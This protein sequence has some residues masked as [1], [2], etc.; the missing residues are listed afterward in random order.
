VNRFNLTF[1]GEIQPGKDP[2]QVKARFGKLFGIDD[3]QR[4]ERFFSG[5]A[6]ILRRNL[7]RKAAAEYFSKLRKLGAEAEL[8]KVTTEEAAAALAAT[9]T[10]SPRTEP[11]PPVAAVE[12]TPQKRGMDHDI[13]Q[14]QPG[15]VDQ[16]WAVSTSRGKQAKKSPTSEQDGT[17]K[18]REKNARQAREEAQQAEKLHLEAEAQRAAAQEQAEQ[19]EQQR[20]EAARLKAE[21]D[22]RVAEVTARR[23]AQQ[24]QARLEAEEEAAREKAL[25]EEEK[26]K[27]EEEARQ[28]AAAEAKRK[29]A[30]EAKRKAAE[31]AERKA[32]E[33]AK[34][35]A[36]EEAKRKAAE[37][38][39]RKA[40]EEAE[41]KAAEEAKR[42]AAEEAK[43]KAAEE[44]ERKAAIEAQR[45]A[46]EE[47]KRKAAEEAAKRKAQEQ[48]RKAEQAALRKA[49]REEARRKA[50]EEAARRKAERKEQQRLK[51]EQ[52]AREKAEKDAARRKADEET[53]LRQAEEEARQK[54]EQE[55]A[56]R[57]AER[58]R[59]TAERQ[60][61]IAERGRLQAE[62]ERE[63]LQREREELER[64]RVKARQERKKLELERKQVERERKAA[65]RERVKAEQAK[66]AAQQQEQRK[67]MEEGAILRAAQELT[68]QPAL[69]PVT[70]QVKTRLETPR[71]NKR[72]GSK[73]AIQ[74]GAPNLYNLRPFRNT[75]AV[76]E[77]CQQAQQQTQ[78]QLTIAA[79]AL[80]ALLVLSGVYLNKAP[81]QLINGATALAIDPESGPLLLAGDRL[82]LHDRAGLGTGEITLEE[83]GISRLADSLSFD[84]KGNLL[85]LG[86][87]ST[88][89]QG[90]REGAALLRC[91]LQV[92]SCEQLFPNANN[93]GFDAFAIHPLDDS[94]F[95]VNANAGQLLHL[96]ADGSEL[97]SAEIAL[98]PLARLGL[99]SGLLFISSAAGP[100]ISVFRYDQNA[101]GKQLDEILL[102][103]PPAAEKGESRVHDFLWSTNSWW[104]IMQ[105][106]ES[107]SASVY[108]FDAQWDFL[109]EPELAAGTRPQRLINWGSKTLVLD[110]GKIQ[111]QRFNEDGVTEAPLASKLL[112]QLATQQQR[113]QWLSGLGWRIVLFTLGALTLIAAVLAWLQ[114]T[115]ALVYRSHKASGAAPIDDLA[116]EIK[117]IDR[118]AQRGAHFRRLIS[119]YAVLCLAALTTA[120]GTGL[121]V[122][123]LL[124]LLLGLLG[125]GIGL[126]LLQRSHCGHL[127]I[128]REQLVL[129][130][131]S[132]MYHLGGDARLQ[133]RGPFLLIDDV[134]LFTGTRLFP[135]FSPAQVHGEV[136]VLAQGGIRVDRK[137][138]L[139]KLLQSQHPLVRAL[140][141]TLIGL[142]LALLV[143]MLQLP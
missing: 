25:A 90:G 61:E 81:V 120:I 9:N 57:K 8:V 105:N 141:I 121:P 111:L 17:E 43:R 110:S 16:S 18:A 35:K 49:A 39:K 63:K 91:Q 82:L 83:L 73:T 107:G 4:L 1:K 32:A 33:K 116:D 37:E 97:N 96:Q 36:A 44:A 19:E 46:A 104:V 98:P 55:E 134:V 30:E 53:A 69:K 70:A 113:G 119:L 56:R 130:D 34:R 60:Q 103:P 27:A 89:A 64:E 95:G 75:V 67:A 140:E 3:P 59:E 40:A 50:A 26:R 131:H 117:W 100:A 65:E 76:K 24:E 112:Q 21:Q 14:R 45:K 38:A 31:E 47:A 94:I 99:Q 127:G 132:D 7:D 136:Q 138:V 78:R 84:S 101:F 93:A 114:S 139:V 6:I 102:L 129:V 128:V 52:L 58:D 126:L 20:R 92:P 72:K 109:G 125:P 41:R 143:S 87:L 124:A 135:A 11:D 15:Q 28:K 77:R 133:Y 68:R 142:G 13:L 123:Y 29:A 10:P 2:G 54:A 122:A 86:E 79:L 51:A 5:D 22:A 80:A 118:V 108:R 48:A 74:A 137:T 88:A 12:K 62:R 106:P 85:A 66:R 115:R 71:G 42:K 23:K